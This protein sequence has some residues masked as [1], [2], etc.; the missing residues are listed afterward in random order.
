[1]RRYKIPTHKRERSG[2]T[3]LHSTFP[4]GAGR[5]SRCT[6]PR[7][8]VRQADKFRTPRHFASAFGRIS[9]LHQT[10]AR[11]STRP[12]ARQMRKSR[13]W[14]SQWSWGGIIKYQPTNASAAAWRGFILPFLEV[15]I[16]ASSAK[17]RRDCRYVFGSR[18]FSHPASNNPFGRK[19]IEDSRSSIFTFAV[20]TKHNFAPI[21]SRNW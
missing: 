20:G 10:A 1:M 15:R 18:R 7:A 16:V 12:A 17:G 5:R 21:P 3:R 19:I 11:P 13:A 6:A 2:M 14:P 8:T 4:W 9:T